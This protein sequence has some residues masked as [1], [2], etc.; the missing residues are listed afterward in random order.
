MRL[1]IALSLAS[2]LAG[3]DPI[4]RGPGWDG[5]IVHLAGTFPIG[6]ESNFVLGTRLEAGGHYGPLALLAEYTF[7]D[8]ESSSPTAA[9]SSGDHAHRVGATARVRFGGPDAD[10][11]YR[12]TWLELG[13][14]EQLY[15]PAAHQTRRDLA[16][17]AGW[18]MSWR[19]VRDIQVGFFFALRATQAEA[20]AAPTEFQ[21]PA[22]A[23]PA[24]HGSCPAMASAAGYDRSILFTA[25]VVFGN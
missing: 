15:G 13:T 14:G 3:A 5:G 17:G 20:P 19:N 7:Y 11:H 23:S 2:S 12:Y 8:F 21:V 16:A 18:Q 9:V 10:H 24:C 4:D 25:G 1:A 22:G 6:G